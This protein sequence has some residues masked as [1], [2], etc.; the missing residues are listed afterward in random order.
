MVQRMR[1]DS[2]SQTYYLTDPAAGTCT[3]PAGKR[4]QPCKHL[5]RAKYRPLYDQAREALVL[6]K[7]AEDDA[8]VDRIY[9]QFV[10]DFV[11]AGMSRFTAKD[12]A[13]NEI[14]NW[15]AQVAEEARG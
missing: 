10:A 9:A 1:S 6:S 14:L 15:G 4:G 3:C 11:K 8:A 7:K 12:K 5:L 13:I 2:D